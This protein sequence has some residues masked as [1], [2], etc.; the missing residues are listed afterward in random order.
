M[1]KRTTII[2]L[3]SFLLAGCTSYTSQQKAQVAELKYELVQPESEIPLYLT[4]HSDNTF[5]LDFSMCEFIAQ[6]AGKYTIDKNKY[7]LDVES[8]TNCDHNEYNNSVGNDYGLPTVDIELM[9]ISETELAVQNEVVRIEN[10][11]QYGFCA[12]GLAALFVIV[13]S[14]I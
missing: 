6:G 3:I 2:I 14:E 11:Q 12:P 9:K 4:L 7:L 13:S 1:Y 8:C 10:G 5:T